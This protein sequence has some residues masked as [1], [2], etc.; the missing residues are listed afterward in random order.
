MHVELRNL[1]KRFGKVEALRSVSLLL[2]TGSRTA[3]IGSF[4]S[5]PPSPHED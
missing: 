3:L 2:P 1:G 5:S 4:I